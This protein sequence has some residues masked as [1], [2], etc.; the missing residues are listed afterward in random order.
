MHMMGYSRQFNMNLYTL[1]TVYR[2]CIHDSIFPSQYFPLGLSQ[3][4]PPLIPLRLGTLPNPLSQSDPECR[5]V[6]QSVMQSITLFIISYIVLLL[7]LILP[8]EISDY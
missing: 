6:Y 7:L 3:L 1:Y 5:D 8:F 2:T 4:T